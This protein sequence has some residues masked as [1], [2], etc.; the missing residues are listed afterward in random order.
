ML[1]T[2]MSIHHTDDC[3]PHE[4]ALSTQ[5]TTKHTNDISIMSTFTHTS[6]QLITRMT[7]HD[8][9]DCSPCSF[10]ELMPLMAEACAWLPEQQ[11]LQVAVLIGHWDFAELGAT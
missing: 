7:A 10:E 8:T 2:L 6:E 9:N 11:G 3:S 4:Y 5:M 1:I